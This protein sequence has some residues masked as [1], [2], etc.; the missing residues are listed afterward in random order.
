MSVLPVKTA[1]FK[2]L[3]ITRLKL[4]IRVRLTTGYYR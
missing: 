2:F 4:A 3:K 1:V